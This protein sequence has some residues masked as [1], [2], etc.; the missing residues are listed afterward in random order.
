MLVA[1]VALFGVSIVI[2]AMEFITSSMVVLLDGEE[3]FC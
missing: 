3:D 1:F 2:L